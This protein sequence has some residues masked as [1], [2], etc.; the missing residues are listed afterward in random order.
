[1]LGWQLE[2]DIRIAKF[3][4][5]RARR[6]RMRLWKGSGYKHFF[7]ARRCLRRKL[8]NTLLWI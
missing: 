1:M 7:L 3:R 5:W 2:M 8:R 6:L 4:R